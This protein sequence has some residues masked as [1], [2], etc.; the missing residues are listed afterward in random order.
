MR[1][2]FSKASLLVAFT[3]A[4]LS[5]TLLHAQNNFITGYVTDSISGEKLINA[6]I[7]IN[8]YTKGTASNNNGYYTIR[9]KQGHTTIR[10][11]YIGY[12]TKVLKIDV[13]KDTLIS[14]ALVPNLEV[15]EVTIEAKSSRF[16]NFTI[17]DIPIKQ[18]KQA[19]AMMGE[20]DIQKSVQQL[21]SVTSTWA[22]FAGMIVRGGNADQ[23]LILIDDIPI[24][25]S[26]HFYGLFSVINEN[27][28]QSARFI[29]GA[30][31]A[32]FGSRL[33]SVL[34]ITLKDG[35]R[36]R[37]EGEVAIG[38]MSGNIMLNG[39]L[40]NNKTTYSFSGRRSMYDLAATTYNLLAKKPLE[41]SFFGDAT[42]KITHTFSNRDKVTISL[43]YSI[44]KY[45]NNS[46]KNYSIGNTT[47]ELSQKQ[48]YNWGNY[49][50]S[51]KWNRVH[52]PMISFSNTVFFSNFNHKRQNKEEFNSGSLDY[53]SN[54]EFISTINDIGVRT[55]WQYFPHASHKFYFGIN[56][57]LHRFAPGSSLFYDNKDQAQEPIKRN[58]GREKYNLH[59]NISYLEYDVTISPIVS[60]NIGVR[61][62][63]IL[64]KEYTKL[65]PEPRFT[66]SITISEKSNLIIYYTHT[67]QYFHLLRTSIL[68]QPTDMWVPAT[69]N[70][71][72]EKANQA[73]A[74]WT[75]THSSTYEV[76]IA[77]YYKSMYNLISYKEGASVLP[78]GNGWEEKMEKGKGHSY[79]AELLI[80]KKAGKLTGWIAYTLAWSKRQ[81][82]SINKGK[83]FYSP[84]DKR[85]EISITSNYQLSSN[86]NFG[87]NWTFNTG[88]PYSMPAYSIKTFNT[89]ESIFIYTTKNNLRLPAYHRLDIGAHYTKK[90]R[91]HKKWENVWSF[92]VYNAY[93]R[94]NV[95]YRWMWGYFPAEASLFICLPSISYK[96]R[97]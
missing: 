92:S 49:I 53:N 29:N 23:N 3:L 83:E 56:H 16:K 41:G 61:N 58:L 35:N 65:I 76:S 25:N 4:F 13:Q 52:N 6:N 63:L 38:I 71:P 72:E 55:D 31:P 24:Y 66:S 28:L 36:R 22:G 14:I 44:D 59:E 37:A 18:V 70:F 96:L 75:Y 39:P 30:I 80:Q 10:C 17:K 42:A 2:F 89:N 85:H 46:K 15:E 67:S 90:H 1:I 81:F 20:I 54:V 26:S 82:N 43:L 87:A 97:F 74:E 69:K 64:S 51:T 12:S 84:F 7:Y 40:K 78:N 8:E 73:G 79:G 68:E 19:P 94:K 88:M 47:G 62:T 93:A 27:A 21:P 11:S 33:S 32:R 77:S 45:Y 60:I 91:K 50:L 86:W 57:T 9:T 48:G 5:S 34:D 95:Y